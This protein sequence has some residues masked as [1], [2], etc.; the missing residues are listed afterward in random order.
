MIIWNL[1][2]IDWTA[3]GSIVTFIA[4][5]MTLVALFYSNEQERKNRQL[6][7]L[8]LRQE[9]QQKRLDEMIGNIL[10]IISDIDP[11]HLSNFSKKISGKDVSVEDKY[12]IDNILRKNSYN[13][14]KLQIQV[15]RQEDYITA[16]SIL[17]RLNK[18]RS[19]YSLWCKSVAMILYYLL[20]NNSKCE[21]KFETIASSYQDMIERCLEIAP[22]SRSDLDSCINPFKD[23][24][25]EEYIKVL[26]VFSYELTPKI[27]KEKKHF[28]NELK[29]FVKNEQKSIDNLVN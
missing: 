12:Q 3:I 6:Q 29:A 27:L 1:T 20:D 25:V 2:T 17:Q 4:L 13:Y 11:L 7:V 5:I 9:Q 22:Q 8:L 14:N 26:T 23:D 28:M 16:Q 15:I 24:L 10:D 18:I 21:E 19:D